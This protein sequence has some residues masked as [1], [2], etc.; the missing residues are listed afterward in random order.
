MFFQL[1][2]NVNRM[3]IYHLPYIYQYINIYLDI[4]KNKI[5]LY[6]LIIFRFLQLFC[7]SNALIWLI[8]YS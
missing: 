8:E 2:F 3:Y 6:K 5:V 7:N 4:E 1:F